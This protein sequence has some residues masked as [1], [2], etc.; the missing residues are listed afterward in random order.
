MTAD[1]L[2]PPACW[3]AASWLVNRSGG[4]FVN[5]PHPSFDVPL[6]TRAALDAVRAQERERC[7]IAGGAAADAGADGAG[8]AAAIRAKSEDQT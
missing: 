1:D 6:Y 4:H 2:P 8:V 5:K 3:T 7:A